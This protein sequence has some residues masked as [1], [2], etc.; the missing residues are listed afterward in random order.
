M[1]HAE[2][3]R[4]DKAEAKKLSHTAVG[5]QHPAKGPDH[6]SQCEHFVPGKPLSCELVKLPIHSNDWCEKFK[7]GGS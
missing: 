4:T 5:F 7:D 3:H 2:A 6:C 1:I